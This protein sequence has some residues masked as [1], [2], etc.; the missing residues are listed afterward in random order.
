MGLKI[1][2]A[3]YACRPGLGSETGVGW[4]MVRELAKY[5]E[6]WVLTRE[7][8]QPAIEAELAQDPIPELHMVYSNLPGFLRGWK[9]LG[10]AVQLHYFLWQLSAYRIARQLHCQIGFNLSHHVT[11]G[12]YCAPSFLALLPIPFVWGPVGGGESAPYSFWQDFSWQGRAYEVLRDL[13][14]WMGELN[15]LVQF[16]ARRSTIALASTPE[17]AARLG[18]IGAKR[19]EFISGQTAISPQELTQLQTLAAAKPVSTQQPVRFLSLGRLLHWKGFHLG[20]RAFAQV[21]LPNAEYWVVGEGPEQ[22]RLE[23]LTNQLGIGDR[24]RFFGSLSRNKALSVLTECDVL[25]HPSLHDFSP[26]VCLEAMAA[27]KPVLCLELGGP[28]YQITEKTGCRVPAHNPEQAVDDLSV[29]MARLASDVELRK[30][31]GGAGQ[32]RVN[33]L[34]NWE[35]RGKALIQLYKTIQVCSE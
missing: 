20:L 32:Q 29:A 21:S 23:A 17:T 7:N 25:V 31:M 18:K 14:R 16:T 4:N 30:Q 10:W 13:S 1:L 22:R 24:V 26:T 11:Y 15:P 28:A 6:V 27:G 8:N 9:K 2:V 3:A 33:E 34:Y 12:R 19:I 5:H 35:T